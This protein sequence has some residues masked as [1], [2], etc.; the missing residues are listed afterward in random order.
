MVAV[1][2][3]VNEAELIDTHAPRVAEFAGSVAL[4]AE[5]RDE[6]TPRIE[7]LHAMLIAISSEHLSH[8]IERHIRQALEFAFVLPESTPASAVRTVHRKNL[9]KRSYRLP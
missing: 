1:I 2:A 5:A 9:K 4:S 7:K 8:R 6:A 3:D